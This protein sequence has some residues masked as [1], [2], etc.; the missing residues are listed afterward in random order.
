VRKI[1]YKTID[2]Y[3]KTFPNEIQEK[4]VTIRN[5]IKENIPQ[6]ATETIS[7]QIPTFKLNGKYVIYFAGYKNH[8]SIYPIPQGPESYKKEIEPFVKGK[9]TL[10]F[11]NDKELPV[12]TIKKVIKYSVEAHRNRS[13]NY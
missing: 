4:L 12:N 2:E 6:D 8:L 13:K 7:Y 5:L 10:Q 3:I 11:P 9:G 1:S